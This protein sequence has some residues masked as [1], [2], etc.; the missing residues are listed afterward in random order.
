MNFFGKK[1]APAPAPTPSSSSSSSSSSI[2][3]PASV[4]IQL[5]DSM[6]TLEK[7]E[8]HISKK[9]EAMH[10]E[11]KA[12]LAA[13]DKKGALFSLKRRKMYEAEVDKIQ[14]SKMTIETQIMSLESSIQNME[15]FRAMKSGKEAMAKVR[16]NIDIGSVDDIMD[17]I[18]EEMDLAAEI[19]DAIGQPVSDGFDED[20][21]LA[22]LNDMEKQDLE[23]MML[24]TP[25][26]EGVQEN[27]GKLQKE[28]PAAP[29][30]G[31]V[32]EPQ[33]AEVVKE[34]DEDEMALRELAAS[35]AV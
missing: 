13:G 33:E 9:S 31:L 5:R 8:E 23:E 29:Q 3:Q 28:M 6:K 34:E 18:K 35:M 22:E 24:S 4:I 21:L 30:G 19:S 16:A 14:G 10:A 1:R 17:D 32:N 11:A 7:R 20:E 12:K 15:T 2:S 27:V 25:S 26:V